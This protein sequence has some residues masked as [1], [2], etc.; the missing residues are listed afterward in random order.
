MLVAVGGV[1]RAITRCGPARERE[2]Q[3]R[4]GKI[5][6]LVR[7]SLLHL[8]LPPRLF[9]YFL[10]FPLTFPLFHLPTSSRGE[11]PLLICSVANVPAR[12]REAL[13]RF[14]LPAFSCP[15]D[16]RR[17]WVLVDGRR[18]PLLPFAGRPSSRLGT[19][20]PFPMFPGTRRL[21]SHALA[22]RAGGCGGRGAGAGS[23]ARA[24][25]ST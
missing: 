22:V 1:V 5:D 13:A 10:L 23:A 25:A 12:A 19:P 24:A 8:C 20:R 6:L 18:V 21:D 11:A 15:L 14:A 9:F 3:P 17:D 2:N 16:E 7:S 4:A